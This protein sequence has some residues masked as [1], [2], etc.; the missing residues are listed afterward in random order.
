MV[1]R[2]SDPSK[3]IEVSA[4]KDASM[5]LGKGKILL[6]KQPVSRL[7]TF[8]SGSGALPTRGPLLDETG[9]SG[10]YDF[11]VPYQPGQPN[12]VLDGLRQYGL[13]LER[14]QRE[15]EILVIEKKD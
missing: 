7:V 11:D 9:L 13:E 10:V 2:R 15:I 8:L 1:L 5:E 6:L 12:V 14:A 4:S 3:S